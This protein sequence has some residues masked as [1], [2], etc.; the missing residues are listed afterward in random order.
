MNKQFFVD[1]L[2][3]ALENLKNYGVKGVKPVERILEDV[4]HG[5]IVWEAQILRNDNFELVFNNKEQ[6]IEFRTTYSNQVIDREFI[7]QLMV[8]EQNKGHIESLLQTIVKF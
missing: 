8:I 2:V 1:Q 5:M 4:E 7:N 6:K 3:A